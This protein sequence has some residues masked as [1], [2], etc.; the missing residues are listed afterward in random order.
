MIATETMTESFTG[1]AHVF[2]NA[3]MKGDQLIVKIVNFSQ[4]PS[5]IRLNLG[6]YQVKDAYTLSHRMHAPKTPSSILTTSVCALYPC[7]AI[8]SHCRPILFAMLICESTQ[9]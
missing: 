9:K 1:E 2:C 3:G 6:D 4:D 7:Q 5:A 8:H